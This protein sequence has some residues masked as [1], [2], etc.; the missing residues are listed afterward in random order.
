[1]T[2]QLM[3]RVEANDP[4]STYLLANS[5][6]RGFNG[7]QQDHVM[8][9]ELYTRAA[10]LDHSEAHSQLGN[11]Y[12]KGG[13]MK[14]A[15]FHLEAAAISGHEESRFNIGVMDYNSGNKERAVK[16]WTIAASAGDH[17]AMNELRLSFEEGLVSRES[18]DSTLTAYNYSCA[19][20]R[21]EARDASI[22]ALA[23]TI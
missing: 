20:M 9:I 2:E 13:D 5:Y 3:K 16:H 12:Y 8:A 4:T 19:E 15:K 7:F 14:K 21:S 11:I 18:I 17:I 22:Y 10:D 6:H 23:E 1:M